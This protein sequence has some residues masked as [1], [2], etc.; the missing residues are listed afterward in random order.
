M[1]YS[2]IQQKDDKKAVLI[3]NYISIAQCEGSRNEIDS[4]WI[5]EANTPSKQLDRCNKSRES[6]QEEQ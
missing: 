6:P 5:Y 2:I 1:I 4:R 3:S